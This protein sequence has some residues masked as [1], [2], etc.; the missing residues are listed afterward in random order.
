MA[1]L[2][3]IA[4]DNIRRCCFDSLAAIWDFDWKAELIHDLSDP[5]F[6][7]QN[8]TKWAPDIVEHFI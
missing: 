6:D 3:E 2:K 7:P 8:Q 4:M 5:N 1:E